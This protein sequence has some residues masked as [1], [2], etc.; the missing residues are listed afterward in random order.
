MTQDEAPDLDKS[1]ESKTKTMIGKAMGGLREISEDPILRAGYERLS[2][3]KSSS[4]DFADYAD[5]H[6]WFFNSFLPLI[7]GICG[8]CG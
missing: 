3:R 6:K 1:P 4:A 7:C 8:I 2:G 5:E